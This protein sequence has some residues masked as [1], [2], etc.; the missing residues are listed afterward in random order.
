MDTRVASGYA[1]KVTYAATV[2]RPI[3]CIWIWSTIQP[4]GATFSMISCF[5]MSWK[6]LRMQRIAI[7]RTYGECA[8]VEMWIPEP[9]WDMLAR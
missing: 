7:P 6:S 8:K 4:D 5:V 1:G 9:L 3:Q 2:G